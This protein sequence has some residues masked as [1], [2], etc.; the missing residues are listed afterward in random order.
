MILIWYL[1]NLWRTILDRKQDVYNTIDQV[2]KLC[3]ER[4]LEQNAKVLQMEGLLVSTAATQRSISDTQKCMSESISV[5]TKFIKKHEPH[6]ELIGSVISLLK[7]IKLAIVWLA[8]ILGS[9]SVI[10]A[11]SAV[12]WLYF[13]TPVRLEDFIF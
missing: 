4:N 11:T 12:V 6:L 3:T 10:V 2:A 13:T 8:A 5:I 9:M 7:G 1:L